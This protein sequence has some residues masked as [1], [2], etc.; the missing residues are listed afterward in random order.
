MWFSH[1]I[2]KRHKSNARSQRATVAEC[3]QSLDASAYLQVASMVSWRVWESGEQ[4]NDQ[5]CC[6]LRAGAECGSAP[7]HEQEAQSQAGA[8]MGAVVVL[9]SLTHNHHWGRALQPSPQPCKS[10][11]HLCTSCA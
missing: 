7:C 3:D 11:N 5:G 8:H 1:I 10:V 4:G 6:G 9:A 2:S